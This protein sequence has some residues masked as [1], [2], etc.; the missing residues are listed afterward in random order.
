VSE[1]E[2]INPNVCMIMFRIEHCPRVRKYVQRIAEKGGD[3]ANCDNFKV[4]FPI[5]FPVHISMTNV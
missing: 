3:S 4:C 1:L 2:E 5:P